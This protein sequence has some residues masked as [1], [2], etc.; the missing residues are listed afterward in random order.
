MEDV[1]CV[2]RSEVMVSGTLGGDGVGDSI[3]GDPGGDEGGGAVVG[4]GGGER[5]G[6]GPA[7]GAV[8]DGEDVCVAL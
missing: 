3:A 1:N 6:F 4:G 2:P 5:S 8:N 7:G